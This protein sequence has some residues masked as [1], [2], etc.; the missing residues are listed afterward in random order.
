MNKIVLVLKCPSCGH[1]QDFTS[2]DFED[3]IPC[4]KCGENEEAWT[5]WHRPKSAFVRKLTEEKN[6]E[7]WS[8]G[9]HYHNDV[10]LLTPREFAKEFYSNGGHGTGLN[11]WVTIHSRVDGTTFTSYTFHGY[12][13]DRAENFDRIA[14]RLNDFLQLLENE[15]KLKH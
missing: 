9:G 15:G 14:K 7:V 4:E 12:G 10:L 3:W 6:Q 13:W 11:L 5:F 2:E 8:Y 1:E